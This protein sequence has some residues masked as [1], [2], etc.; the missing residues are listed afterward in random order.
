M[1]IS[2][3]QIARFQGIYRNHF[4]VDI[5]IESAQVEGESLVQLMR[6]VKNEYAKQYERNDR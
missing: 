1:K 3:E 5:S 4:G 2:A 6:I